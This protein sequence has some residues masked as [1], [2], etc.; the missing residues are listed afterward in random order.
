MLFTLSIDV[1]LSLNGEV[2]PNHGY[3][4]I[5]DIGCSDTTALLCHT[6]KPA[7]DGANSGGDWFAPDG[8]R[9]GG[10]S[11]TD[12]PGF[13]R[14]RGPMVV[15]LRRNS[16]T[17]DEGIYH[18]AIQEQGATSTTKVYVGLYNT[19]GGMSTRMAHNDN[20]SHVLPQV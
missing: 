20:T 17:P 18:C 4:E 8:T 2:I 15:R 3:V 9:V 14:N 13:G 12:V 7:P 10:F 16:G 19:G 11:S 5:S 1:Y 6:N